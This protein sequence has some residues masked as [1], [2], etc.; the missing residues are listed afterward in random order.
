MKKTIVF[1]IGRKARE[2]ARK[3]GLENIEC[4]ADSSPENLKPIVG[5]PV[6]SFEEMVQRAPEYD[7]ILSIRLEELEQKLQMHN[8]HYWTNDIS[9]ESY[10][11]RQDVIDMLDAR[12]LDRYYYDK[13]AKLAL[14]A[15]RYED[16]FREEFLSDANRNLVEAF[17][18][19]NVDFI[20]SFF[21]KNYADNKMYCDEYYNTRP[22]MRLIRN[23]MMESMRG[24]RYSSVCD[25]ACG[26]GALLKQLKADGFQVQGVERSCVRAEGIIKS[27]ISCTCADVE[28]V[29]FDD[30]TFNVVVCMECLEHIGAPTTVVKEAYRILR[31]SGMIFCTTPYGRWCDSDTH[32]RHFDESNLCTLLT[33]N[34]FEIVN[35]LRIPY[36]NNSLNDNLFVAAIKK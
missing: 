32:L 24:E 7:I 22:G 21:E 19:K 10:F 34:G 16:C 5:I 23:I 9:K 25:L 20:Q 8:V 3:I 6:I 11:M 33:Q 17:K 18:E 1:E 15:Q 26:H 4:F 29:P 13:E 27:G 30:E 14:Y 36:L 28:N 12:L 31:R 35:I 2:I